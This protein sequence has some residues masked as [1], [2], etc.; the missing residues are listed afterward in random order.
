[1]TQYTPLVGLRC[2][3]TVVFAAVMAM[4]GPVAAHDGEHPDAPNP[5]PNAVAAQEVG[6]GMV[7]VEYGR[8]GVKGREGKIWG[9]LVP[10]N[11]GNPRPWL[12]GANGN[13]VITFE[14]DVKVNGHELA[15]GS[16]GLMMIP[17]P[18]EWT[19]IFSNNA[20]R[21]GIL[22]YTPEDDALR[23][24]VTP[25]RADYREWLE[26][27]FT[28]TGDVTADLSL[29]WENLKVGFTIDAPDH[30]QEGREKE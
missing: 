19:I 2:F 6:F 26:Y 23:I 24:E 20:N 21:L 16:Y 12:A 28:K 25:E 17:S 13:A 5:S 3:V 14:E 29:H 30:R 8:P 18:E 27:E 22:E 1:M 15:A 9:E 4:S 7:T 11:E 10:Y